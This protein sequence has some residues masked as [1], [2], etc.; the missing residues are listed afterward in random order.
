MGKLKNP[1]AFFLAASVFFT[2][3]AG[4]LF[5]IRNDVIFSGQLFDFSQEESFVFFG[6]KFNLKDSITK[7][8]SQ[9]LSLCDSFATILIPDFF[10]SH[11]KETAKDISLAVTGII[12]D[13][14][15]I[16]TDFVYGKM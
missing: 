11:A 12:F 7:T 10:F 4:A 13:V 6:K 5:V 14:Y 16:A 1:I 9:Y 3:A 2:V 15:D 8:A